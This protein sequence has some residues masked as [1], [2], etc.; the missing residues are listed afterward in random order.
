MSVYSER[1][2]K[3]LY[4]KLN[5]ASVLASGTGLATAVYNA[6]A[7]D[8][9]NLPYLIFHQQASEPIEYA[10]G[11]PTQI[12]EPM[13]WVVQGFADRLSSTSRSPQEVAEKIVQ[14]AL[15]ALG[16]SMTLTGG[17]EVAWMARVNDTPPLESQQGDRYVYQRGFLLRVSVE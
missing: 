6:K 11:G 1:T 7:I 5:V 3:A 10:M 8:N 13:L 9:A 4:A 14:D 17:G 12:L 15:A 2:R 16:T